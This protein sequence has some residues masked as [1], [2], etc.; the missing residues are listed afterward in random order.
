MITIAKK[1]TIVERT[2]QSRYAVGEPLLIK[3]QAHCQGS[4]FSG[5][6]RLRSANNVMM[7]ITPRT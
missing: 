4:Q 3:T 7:W 2:A 1:I 6:K 5:R